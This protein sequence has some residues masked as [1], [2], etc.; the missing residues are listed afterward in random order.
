MSEQESTPNL[1]RLIRQ[2]IGA[3]VVIIGYAV[4]PFE[5]DLN[6][7][8]LEIQRIVEVIGGW[9]ADE[10]DAAN[11]GYA[12]P[13]ISGL[14]IIGA[15]FAA[16]QEL[17]GNLRTS[18]IVIR[19]GRI[20][21]ALIIAIII[22]IWAILVAELD[23]EI[24][25][26][27]TT[28][29]A[30]VI[31]AGSLIMVLTSVAGEPDR[32]RVSAHAAHATADA[33]AGQ[34]TETGNDS[35]VATASLGLAASMTATGAS[36]ESRFQIPD[37]TRASGWGA[38]LVATVLIILLLISIGDRQLAMLLFVLAPFGAMIA[39]LGWLGETLAR[40]IVFEVPSLARLHPQHIWLVSVAAIW[41]TWVI[42]LGMIWM[43]LFWVALVVIGTIGFITAGNFL[44]GERFN[45]LTLVAVG[46]WQRNIQLRTL[47]RGV[48][49]LLATVATIIFLVRDDVWL[50]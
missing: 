45:V 50:F 34:D 22:G 30:W 20:G 37:V 43:T 40:N 23:A 35:S 27:L 21:G 41:T 49:L 5:T 14:I 19:A 24:G 11:I 33:E 8:L 16:S 13:A 4:I 15:G 44:Q 3:I 18:A 17:S 2:A 32:G 9:F 38:A 7:T 31:I 1:G 47:I 48:F 28:P 39:M 42:A 46:K 36:L 25:E 6:L 12:I 26:V 29:S 10:A